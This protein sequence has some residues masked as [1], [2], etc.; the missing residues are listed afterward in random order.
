MKRLVIGV[1]A[2]LLV[3]SLVPL[4][5]CYS[6][7]EIYEHLEVTEEVVTLE[8]LEASGGFVLPVG[9][10]SAEKSS[11]FVVRGKV[12]DRDLNPTG[13]E[14]IVAFES[15]RDPEVAALKVGDIIEYF[16]E[17]ETCYFLKLC[18]R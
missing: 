18:S 10:G 13:E 9:G 7:D 14:D 4:T 12:L 11:I 5:G 15:E 2:V 1:A 8:K 16:C 17:I 6:P 3:V